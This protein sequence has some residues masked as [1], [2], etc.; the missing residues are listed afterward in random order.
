MTENSSGIKIMAECCCM[1]REKFK[2]IQNRL[3]MGRLCGRESRSVS[4]KEKAG[5]QN[6]EKNSR[7]NT[8]FSLDLSTYSVRIFRK[9]SGLVHSFSCRQLGRYP[10]CS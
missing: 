8:P 4:Y 6:D 1:N 9:E 3:S 5:G 10:V 7:Y 2:G